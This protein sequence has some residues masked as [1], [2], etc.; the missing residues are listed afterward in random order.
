MVL[1]PSAAGGQHVGHG[2]A[3]ATRAPRPIVTDRRSPERAFRRIVGL[4]EEVAIPFLLVGGLAARA[5]GAHREFADIDFY[6]PDERLPDIRLR[7]PAVA[8]RIEDLEA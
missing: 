5:S 1:A 6:G 2:L 4:L 8:A 7:S 3:P